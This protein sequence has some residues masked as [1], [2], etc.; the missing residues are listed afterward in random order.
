M[1]PLGGAVPLWTHLFYPCYSC[2]CW[3][4]QG[5]W[6]TERAHSCEDKHTNHNTAPTPNYEWWHELWSGHLYLLVLPSP[7]FFSYISTF[8]LTSSPNS[9]HVW[10]VFHVLALSLGDT[11]GKVSFRQPETGNRAFMGESKSCT[12][13]CCEFPFVPLR[14]DR[15]NSSPLP[16]GREKRER[17]GETAGM[18]RD[19]G[20]SPVSIL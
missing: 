8:S 11:A 7:L 1:S 15:E 3:W 20:S 16:Q 4:G 5:H 18:K 12:V 6:S 17:R 19:T 10:P 13:L 9:H 14:L 2:H